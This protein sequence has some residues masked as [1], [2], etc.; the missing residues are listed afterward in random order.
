MTECVEH[1]RAYQELGFD[2]VTLRVTGWDQFG[3]L[4]RVIDEVIPRLREDRGR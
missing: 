4:K 1:L 3:Q 2:E